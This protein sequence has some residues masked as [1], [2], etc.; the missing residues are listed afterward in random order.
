MPFGTEP[1]PIWANAL[2][3]T[4]GAAGVW[5]A[6]TRL[7]GYADAISEQ[8]GLGHAFVGALLLGGISSL[9]EAATTTTAAA[10]GNAPIAVNNL[11]GGVAMQVAILA[12]ADLRARGDAITAL[13]DESSVLLQ[14]S[15]FIIILAVAGMGSLAGDRL[16]FGVGLWSLAVGVLAVGA[17]LLIRWHPE[18]W[19]PV[20]RAKRPGAPAAQT[21]EADGGLTL[22]GLILRTVVAAAAIL[23]AGIVVALTAD[24]LAEQTG[25]GS[26]FVGAV[27]VALSTSL[28]E[29]STTIAAVGLGAH[30]L[31]FSNVFG[32][33]VLDLGLILVA[34][35][36]YA[37]G[38]VLAAVGTFSAVTA[39]LGIVLTG[40]YATG[41]L[42]RKR[43]VILGMGADS[44]A[45]VAMYMGGLVLLYALR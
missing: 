36:V 10:V 23:V 8:T 11:I 22:G 24:A 35:A 14:M 4:L 9:P 39:L 28:P 45:V 38:P 25:L 16:V 1:L 33:N 41:S 3:F 32:A 37:G 12:L 5:F 21:A 20:R 17:F 34:D 18:A 31:A 15:L 26:N 30:T 27:L 43:R 19:R 7:A 6:G 13:I 40:I 29:I 44:L 2:L 42:R